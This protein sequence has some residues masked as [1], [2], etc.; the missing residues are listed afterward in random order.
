MHYNKERFIDK[1]NAFILK[2]KI[3][4]CY[5]CEK[6]ITDKLV[7]KRTKRTRHYHQSCYEYQ[8]YGTT[9]EKKIY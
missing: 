7:V 6:E 4:I 8:N 9:N 5:K 2:N 3:I 1:K